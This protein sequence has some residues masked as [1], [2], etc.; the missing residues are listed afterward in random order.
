MTLTEEQVELL[1]EMRDRGAPVRALSRQMGKNE[2]TVRY[3]LRKRREA[4]AADGRVGKPT[5][6]DGYGGAVEAVQ[7]ALG[8]GRLTAA[9]SRRVRSTS[10]WAGITATAGVTSRWFGTFGGGREAGG[11]G[12]APGGDGTGGSGAARLV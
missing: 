1:T 3:R 10:C 4:G 5:A 2:A 9:R 8:D 12:G 7:R 11:A 6:L